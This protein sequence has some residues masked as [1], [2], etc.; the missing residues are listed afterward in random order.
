MPVDHLEEFAVVLGNKLNDILLERFARGQRC[1]FRDSFFS[2]VSIS[3]MTLG[4]TP[5]IG[6]GVIEHLAIHRGAG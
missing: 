6:D 5:D 1:G 3:A 2:P 4:K